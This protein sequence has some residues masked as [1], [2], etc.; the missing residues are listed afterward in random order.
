MFVDNLVRLGLSY[1]AEFISRMCLFCMLV[2]A[3][4]L[5]ELPERMP[6]EGRNPGLVFK[7][8]WFGGV[9]FPSRVGRSTIVA[10][11]LWSSVELSTLG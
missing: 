1:F 4:N 7:G 3:G 8:P 11:R 9:N 5:I 6:G 10:Q 2:G